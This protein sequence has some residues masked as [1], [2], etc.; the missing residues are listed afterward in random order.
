MGGM[1]TMGDDLRFEQR[2]AGR[3][4][5]AMLEIVLGR[6]VPLDL[7][8]LIDDVEKNLYSPPENLMEEQSNNDPPEDNLME[9]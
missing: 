2:L 5:L 7:N 3:V 6:R 1:V 8:L 9:E 4:A